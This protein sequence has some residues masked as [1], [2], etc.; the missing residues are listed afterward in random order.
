MPEQTL[1]ALTTAAASLIVSVT[2]AAV[3]YI[4]RRRSDMNLARL[5]DTLI[6][7]RSE[8]S[9]R[10]EYIYEAQKR[11]YTDFQPVLFQMVERCNGAVDRIKGL[12]ESARSG[13]LSWPGRLGRGWEKD[14]YHMI[15]TCWDLLSPLALFR[16]GQQKLTSIDVSVDPVTGW[17]YLLGRELYASWAMGYELAAEEP[18]LPFDDAKRKTRQNILSAHLEQVVDCLIRYG[19]KGEMS[20]LR[21]SEFQSAFRTDP[22]FAGTMTHVTLPLANFHPQSKPVLWRILIAQL[23]LHVA[24]MRT[25]ASVV[26]GRPQRVHPCDALAPA[27]WDAFDWRSDDSLSREE[28][29]GI[30]FRAAR[31]FLGKQLEVK[32]DG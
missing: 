29:V 18:T 15:S 1:I 12:A 24:M 10:R 6:E 28:A 26:D 21:F 7:Q 2:T 23:H 11:L 17:Q 19:D 14:P 8:R 5:E 31:S 22:E 25:F 32:S 13:R 9:A 30:P 27:E 20:C 16:I 4:F 3:T